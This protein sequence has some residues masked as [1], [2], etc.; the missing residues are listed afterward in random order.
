MDISRITSQGVQN[1]L[2]PS[3][4]ENLHLMIL[5]PEKYYLRLK[6]YRKNLLFLY[7]LLRTS[8][9]FVKYM[10]EIISITFELF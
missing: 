4:A 9:C 3:T 10:N 6:L 5:F 8:L 2:K 1:H 7:L